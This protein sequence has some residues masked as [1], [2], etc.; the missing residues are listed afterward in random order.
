[1][2]PGSGA[3]SWSKISRNNRGAPPRHA[4]ITC[5]TLPT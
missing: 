1:M 5:Y 2:G 4:K 3:L